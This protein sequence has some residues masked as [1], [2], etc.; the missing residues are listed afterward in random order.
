MMF[1]YDC[2]HT[3]QIEH[4]LQ[5]FSSPTDP[6]PLTSERAVIE[7]VVFEKSESEEINY[8]TITVVLIAILLIFVF[9]AAVY[10]KKKKGIF[11]R[12]LGTVSCL[13]CPV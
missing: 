9:A 6:V 10:W 1:V 5:I 13:H 12:F 2:S 11:N 3:I 7:K 8:S 4:S